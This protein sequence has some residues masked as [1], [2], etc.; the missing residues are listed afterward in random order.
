MRQDLPKDRRGEV[1]PIS[2]AR[3]ELMRLPEV[4]RGK[5]A[6][7]GPHWAALEETFAMTPQEAQKKLDSLVQADPQQH[8]GMN[9]SIYSAVR[10]LENAFEL[11]P[12][13]RA[14]YVITEQHW[15]R[16]VEE[17]HL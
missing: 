9:Y 12:E 1:C 15:Q 16:I 7:Q 6:A 11:G 5:A 17:N 2:D 3:K 14:G 13:M 4:E 10:L 8:E